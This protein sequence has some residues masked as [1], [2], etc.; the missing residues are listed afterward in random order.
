MQLK[1]IPLALT[2]L[3]VFVSNG[4][5]PDTFGKVTRFE[6]NL[7]SYEKDPDAHAIVLY[8]RGDN[9]FK[10]VNNRIRLVKEYHAKI[11]ILDEKGFDEANI[12]I[13]L[14]RSDKSSEKLRKIRAAT[15]NGDNSFEVLPSE[16]FEK[17]ISPYRTEKSFTF[18]KVQK[19]SILEYQYTTFSPFFYNFKGWDFQANIPKLYSEF[20][21]KIPG[22]YIYN[23]SLVGALPLDTND[24]KIQKNCF[25]VDGYAQSA[26]CEVIKYAM[27]DIPAFKVE[28]DYMLAPSNY[29]SRLD[30]ELSQYTRF[31][32][33][34][35]RFTKSW[36]DVD[37]E[38][39]TDKNIG[40]QLSK[41]GVFEN[42]A[43]EKLLTEGEP[44]ARAKNIYTFVQE[45]YT[46]NE[47]Y[48]IFGKARV[49]EA[50]E[51]RKG[52]VSEINIA[53]INLLNAAGIKANL[54]LLSTRTE[55]LPKKTHPVMSDFNYAIA[56]I[57]ING[58]EYLLDATSKYMPF[59][60]L[61]FRALN[62]YGRVM[63]FKNDSYWYTIK[64]NA[65]NKTL[66]RVHLD[67]NIE[68]ESGNGMMEI[69]NSG[70]HAVD[71]RTKIDE[72][73]EEE[74]LASWEESIAGDFEIT[75]YKTV[76]ERSTKSKVVE[77]FQF[78]LNAILKADMVYFN[79]FL[80]RF[81]EKNPF[82]LEERN[83]PVDF[84][85]KRNYTYQINVAIPKG[86]QVLELPKKQLVNL[87]EKMVK[88]KFHHQENINMISI[89][90]E[91]AL[92][93]SYFHPED[94]E[95]LKQVFKHVTDIQN[96]SLMI[97]K[98]VQE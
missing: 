85:Y 75:S 30:F 26:D 39:Q 41:K 7:A 6:K 9:Y 11:K 69:I 37:R 5:M 92:N 84:G 91:L 20:N 80:I 77:R 25:S 68:A 14:R 27:K 98:K 76:E 61:P 19:G 78:E 89:S 97:L 46:W 3:S 47:K 87:G 66:V 70:Y 82:R 28:E 42:H 63:D 17:E 16:I 34:T 54:M 40:R 71:T 64:P 88:L 35:N 36:E 62:L 51:N 43:S 4:Q 81:F 73:S 74:Y 10:V 93:D 55:G 21:A 23:R 58:Q 49:K 45:H 33:I 15:H 31:D 12:S 8:E 90:F 29:I 83:Y 79:P 53:L 1:Y 48:G 56:K 22:N 65:N 95:G 86:Y 59:G 32:G 50:F 38:F 67:F 52:N 24:S 2:I 44:L 94:Y 18:P 72:Y 60:M 13:L 96:N 57:E